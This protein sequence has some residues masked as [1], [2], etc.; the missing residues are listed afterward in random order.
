M[1]S[2]AK[3]FAV[4]KLSTSEIIATSASQ[5]VLLKFP[6]TYKNVVLCSPFPLA[7]LKGVLGGDYLP[8]SLLLT[9]YYRNQK[10]LAIL[11]KTNHKVD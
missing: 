9:S 5:I 6:W 11:D 7:A 3:W 1:M 8:T 4:R 10:K 2:K